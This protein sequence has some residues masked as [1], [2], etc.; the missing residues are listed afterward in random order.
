MATWW[1]CCWQIPGKP[2]I[3]NPWVQ[4]KERHS[5]FFSPKKASKDTSHPFAGVLDAPQSRSATEIG[6]PMGQSL[7][8]HWGCL[9]IQLLMLLSQLLLLLIRFSCTVQGQQPAPTQCLSFPMLL[10]CLPPP[11]K[12]PAGIAALQGDTDSCCAGPQLSPASLLCLPLALAAWAGR[13]LG[14]P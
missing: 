6:E 13:E 10:L 11:S 3:K 14:E 12:S 1:Q 8:L 4:T 7:L 5:A 2:A 9:L